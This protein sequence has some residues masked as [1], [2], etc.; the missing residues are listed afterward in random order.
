MPTTRSRAR[1]PM[2]WARCSSTSA[3]R[4]AAS[5]RTCRASSP[6]PAHRCPTWWTWSRSSSTSATS[7]ATTRSMGSSSPT[8]GR[9]ARRSPCTSCRIRTC[10]SRSRRS[11]LEARVM[12]APLNLARWIDEHRDLLKPPVGNA[13]VWEDADFIVTRR[14]RTEPAHGLPRRSARGVLLPAHRRHGAADHGRRRPARHAD[15]RRRRIPAAAARAP[16]AAASRWQR[17]PRHRVPQAAGLV[18]HSSGIASSAMHSCIASRC[19]LRASCATCRRCSRDSTATRR[20]ASA[21]R[22]APCI[23]ARRRRR[24]P[25]D[26]SASTC[27]PTSSRASRARRRSRRTGARLARRPWRRQR[28]HHAGRRA[29]PSGRGALWDA[30]ARLRWM[31]DAGHRHPV[32][33]RHA[34]H[35]RLR[36]GRRAAPPRG[37]A[38]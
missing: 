11:R 27:M 19:S 26:R 20:C 33:L 23:P 4:R 15:S 31:D 21:R 6:Q 7:A 9:R 13:Q 18:E 35:V 24:S 12:R 36:V 25:S 38:A 28:P 8:T 14:R 22:A 30:H 10:A 5:S 3:S 17:R 34:G 16:F 29:L 32:R 37:R 1:P 2:P